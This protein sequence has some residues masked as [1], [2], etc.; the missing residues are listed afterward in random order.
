MSC[1]RAGLAGLVVIVVLA[2]AGGTATAGRGI[3]L[4][5]ERGELGRLSAIARGFSFTTSSG[6][7]ACDITRTIT[8]HRMIPKTVGVLAGLVTRVQVSNCTNGTVRVLTESLPWHLQYNSFSGTLPNPGVIN[9]RAVNLSWLVEQMSGLI[10]CLYSGTVLVG[11]VI[12]GGVMVE[13]RYGPEGLTL[14]LSRSLGILPCPET[15]EL[16]GDLR[17]EPT[18][19]IRLVS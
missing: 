3:E 9:F 11:G 13:I 6:V 17:M 15:M 12:R 18:P 14:R 1:T 2:L 4:N 7:V 5:L 16:R 10:Q 8:L 19:I